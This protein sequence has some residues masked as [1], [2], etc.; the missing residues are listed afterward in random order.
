MS[1]YICP[2]GA[3]LRRLQVRT[4]M[5]PAAE[6]PLDARLYPG[7][8]HSVISRESSAVPAEAFSVLPRSALQASTRTLNEE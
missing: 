5:G 1:A 8:C 7:T 3:H 6:S 4:A 2:P